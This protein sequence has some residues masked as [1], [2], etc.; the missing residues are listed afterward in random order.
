MA[1][2]FTMKRYW[3]TIGGGDFFHDFFSTVCGR[4]ENEQWGS[5]YPFYD[6]LAWRSQP[7][8][9]GV[10]PWKNRQGYAEKRL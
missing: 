9:V 2:G 8:F 5:K 10:T 7:V 4:L 6:V 3:Y 1:V